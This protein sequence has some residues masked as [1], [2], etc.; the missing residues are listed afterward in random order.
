M[1]KMSLKKSKY[2]QKSEDFEETE[3]VE[4]EALEGTGRKNSLVGKA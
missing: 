4:E 3:V 1:A 2:T